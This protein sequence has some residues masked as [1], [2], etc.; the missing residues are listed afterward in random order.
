MFVRACV[1]VSV[2]AACECVIMFRARAWCESA[3]YRLF[4][5]AYVA[6]CVSVLYLCA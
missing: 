6:R 2:F 3:T 5:C 4:V 1:R